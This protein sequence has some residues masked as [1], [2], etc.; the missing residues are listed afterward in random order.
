VTAPTVRAVTSQRLDG[1][2]VAR[3]LAIIG[4][5]TR[6][7]G[8][9]P[10]DPAVG[11]LAWAYTRTDGRASVL[12][13][14]VAGI[15]VALVAARSDVTLLRWRLV[16]R[17]AWLLPLGLWLQQLDHDVLVILHP[18]AL[19]FLAVLPFVRCRDGTLLVWA[20][21][22][23]V[24]GSGAVLTAVVLTPDLVLPLGG[25]PPNLLLELVLF[26]AY[27]A[28]T[29]LPP[30]LVGLWLGRRD[31]SSPT[32]QAR[33]M[34][35]GLV[36][37]AVVTAA[38]IVLPTLTGVRPDETT[39]SW[40]LTVDG[41]SEMPLALLGA[42][43]TAVALVG[44]S[45][46]LA[47]RFP[48]ALAPLTAFGRLALSVYVAHLLVMHVAS[49]LLVGDEVTEGIGLVAAVTATS[50]VVAV[51]WLARFPRGPLEQLER[52][53]WRRFVVPATQRRH[54]V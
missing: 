36:T 5:L 8:P 9:R 54:R 50:T 48:R 52:W 49:D 34:T 3:G 38:S 17:A 40:A 47:G 41:H 7:I 2:D 4:M 53:P 37:L 23:T 44:A 27:P 33:M 28:V 29:Y 13:V 18:Y 35:V 12:F 16:Y 6:H 15:G 19:F 24:V 20:A 42:T 46:A 11:T 10:D 22:L 51:V 31:L 45:Q 14:L 26:G 43:G 30:M 39:W 32:V 25:E 1:V 21:G